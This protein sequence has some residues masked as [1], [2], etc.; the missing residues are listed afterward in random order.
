[1]AFR[2]AL[3]VMAK[4]DVEGQ[5]ADCAGNGDELHGYFLTYLKADREA[6]L[7]RKEMMAGALSLAIPFCVTLGDC[8]PRDLRQCRAGCVVCAL[9][10]V[11]MRVFGT[12]SEDLQ[13]SQAGFRVEEVLSL[14]AGNL[15]DGVAASRWW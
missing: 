2:K 7:P 9:F 15:N 8:L 11:S 14:T 13:A 6:I 5:A 10:R 4:Q 1:M 3:K 12:E